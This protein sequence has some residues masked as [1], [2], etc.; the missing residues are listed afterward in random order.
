MVKEKERVRWRVLGHQMS[1][2]QAYVEAS[3]KE[4]A[5]A[6]AKILTP[7]AWDFD[8]VLGDTTVVSVEPVEDGH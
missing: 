1:Q 3:T 6:T 4:E 8:D 2:M 5:E 7:S